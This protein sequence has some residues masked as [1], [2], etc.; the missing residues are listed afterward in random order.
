MTELR[1]AQ[2]AERPCE[3]YAHSSAP[4]PTRT[5]GHHPKPVYLQMRLYGKVIHHE[6]RYY[7]GLCH[8]STHDW[9]SWLLGEARKPDP[10]PGAKTKAEA[11]RT[12]LWYRAEEARLG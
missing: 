5:Q 12:Y 9:L 10:E 1:T 3:L 8:D 2:A 11:L 7:C 4:K 6:L